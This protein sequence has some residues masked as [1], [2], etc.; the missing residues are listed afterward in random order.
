MELRID[1]Q[2]PP[3]TLENELATLEQR[4]NTPDDI[5]HGLERLTPLL[6]DLIF[7]YRE[8]DGEHYVYV[9]DPQRRRLA[10]YT[11][12][13]RLIEIDRRA[14]R[15]LRAPHSKYRPEYRRRGIATAIY[16][17]ALARG[18]C[19][20]SGA[21]QSPGAHAL[22][23]RLGRRHPLGFVD[24][25]CKTLRYL[26]ESV[27]PT[28]REDLHTRMLLLGEGWTLAGLEERAGL[29]LE[30]VVGLRSLGGLLVLRR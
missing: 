27:E 17:W 23:L 2:H 1:V 22:W 5:L 18:F 12:F 3:D 25:R 15:H 29:V 7:H 16:G 4:L 6:P 24:L 28:V 21:R 8:A 10:G 20:L 26:G 30:E 9:E 14:D 13:N 19:L 11:V